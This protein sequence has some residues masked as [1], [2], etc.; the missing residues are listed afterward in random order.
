MKP[1]LPGARVFRAETIA[2][3]ARPNLSRGAVLGDLLEEIAVRVEEKRDAR[4]ELVD[5]EA[6][7]HA[8]LHILNAV[9]QRERQ[10]LGRGRARFANV[11][12][13]D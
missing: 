7:V 13:A 5:V 3:D 2:H 6:G 8:P 9:A 1:Q 4:H 12:A 11:I 10:L